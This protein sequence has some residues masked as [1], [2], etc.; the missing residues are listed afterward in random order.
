[1]RPA[2]T[3]RGA[4]APL[5]ALALCA[6]QVAPE[7]PAGEI[8]NPYFSRPEWKLWR[9]DDAPV[10]GLSS[11]ERQGDQEQRV[12]ITLSPLPAAERLYP[13]RTGAGDR[14]CFLFEPLPTPSP[15]YA[16]LWD[17]VYSSWS[18]LHGYLRARWLGDD[19]S[20][21]SVRGQVMDFVDVDQ[22]CM[23]R[24]GVNFVHQST[25]GMGHAIANGAI[26][27]RTR[28]FERLYFANVLIAAPAHASFTEDD[29]E[30][31]TDL[32]TAQIPTLFNSV[33][34]SNSET[35]AI[36]KLAIAGAY[37]PPGTKSLLKRNGLY[38]AALLSIWKA[39]L[40]YDLPYGHELR[41]RIAYKAVGNRETY[42]ES[43]GA[44]GIERGDLALEFH[45]Y[46]DTAHMR[47]MAALSSSM[48][49]APPEA[50]LRV[51]EVE[52][53][54]AGG[55]HLKK[56]ALVVSEPEQD[57]VLVVSTEDCYD[58]QDLPV[59]VRWRLLYGNRRTSVT[60]DPEDP[61]L[62]TIRVP[63]DPELPEGRTVVALIA[64]NGRFDS[65]PALCTFYRKRSSTLPP[66]GHGPGDY[67]WPA[68]GEPELCNRRPVILGLQDEAV[69][70]GRTLE[71]PLR[72]IDPEGFGVSFHQPATDAGAIEGSVFRW[73]CP[74][75]EPEGAREVQLIASD[76]TSGNSYAGETL[77]ISVGKPER[78][79]RIRATQWSGPAPLLL[80]LS[81]QESIGRKL[82][83]GW[84]FYRPSRGH[85]PAAFE[86][87]EQGRRVTHVFTE[88][89]VHAIS[90][91]VRN[92]GGMDRETIHIF[93]GDG[94][95]TERP[96]ELELL[97]QN[98]LIP[99]GDTTPDPF[100]GTRFPDTLRGAERSHT[101]L[102]ENRGDLPILL[103]ARTPFELSGEGRRSFKILRR[104]LRRIEPR[105]SQ[106]F[107]ITFSPRTDGTHTATLQ[108]ATGAGTLSCTIAGSSPTGE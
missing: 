26:L 20:A 28:S 103:D 80:E 96:P 34:S 68:P 61:D 88:P 87:L 101:F 11:L 108:I 30:R 83:Y 60:Q 105:G 15:R 58:L 92:S 76:R 106:T 50:L 73:H 31:T 75:G 40:P 89:G 38:A 19:G 98:V 82:E 16:G 53:G 52:G 9:E 94:Q 42:P 55:Y 44:A 99:D 95:S 102:L 13:V 5:L 35:M 104:N 81:A 90:L 25:T 32:Y 17:D 64:S 6:F 91:V 85:V 33:G 29:P 66:P 22:D 23:L 70:P 36:T 84:E 27:E 56:S 18:G 21:V 77:S 86:E 54:A 97:G 12:A 51:I 78:M 107:S 72:A 7:E 69:L 3:R 63:F 45:R 4:A 71:V 8:Q 93:A 41:H 48:D 2:I 47:A 49:V 59:S 62:F 37:L 10:E 57:A 14:P 43:Y 1:M 65:N 39:A 67:A 79:A 24:A 100:D 74:R 46:D